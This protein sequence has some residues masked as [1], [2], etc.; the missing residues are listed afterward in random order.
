MTNEQSAALIRVLTLALSSNRVQHSDVWLL[1]EMLEQGT[2]NKQ[3]PLTNLQI[4]LLRKQVNHRG[5]FSVQHYTKLVE[6][7]H[8]IK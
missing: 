1:S 7:H 2:C 8:N 6:Q 4:N 3:T 5:M